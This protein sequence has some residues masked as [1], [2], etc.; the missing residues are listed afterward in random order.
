MAVLDVTVA[1]HLEPAAQLCT[2]WLVSSTMSM[3][4]IVGPTSVFVTAVKLTLVLTGT[5]VAFAVKPVR[6][7]PSLAQA[8]EPVGVFVACAV[9]EAVAVR[10][11]V[12]VDVVVAVGRV[13]VWVLVACTGVLVGVLVR[14]AVA[15]TVVAVGVLVRGNAVLV[16]V[17]VEAPLVQL[18]LTLLEPGPPPA[19]LELLV[20]SHAVY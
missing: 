3:Y 6:Q 10:V 14:V 2:T 1:L 5:D 17:E 16:G 7:V 8:P 18:T 15:G 19:M 13:A 20:L 4:H 9:G 12:A 11:S